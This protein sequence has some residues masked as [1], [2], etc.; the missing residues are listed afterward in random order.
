MRIAPRDF[1]TL[2]ASGGDIITASGGFENGVL[3]QCQKWGIAP[4]AWSPLGEGYCSTVR[5]IAT[6]PSCKKSLFLAEKYHAQPDQVLL[7]W[8]RKHPAIVPVLGTSKLS[9]IKNAR[10]SLKINLTHE[11]WYLLW[12]AATG[13][14][15][16]QIKS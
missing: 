11:E 16:A 2:Y 5:R 13:T 14:E 6:L 10:Y 1:S 8:L 15:I 7:A 9:R 3:D 4:T 12:Q